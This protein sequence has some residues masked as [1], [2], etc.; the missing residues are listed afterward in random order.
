MAVEESLKPAS[1]SRPSPALLPPHA[2]HGSP[3]REKP[4]AAAAADLRRRERP[5]M[6][7]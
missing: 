6:V 5:A 4:V 3:S 7:E 2:A 1:N